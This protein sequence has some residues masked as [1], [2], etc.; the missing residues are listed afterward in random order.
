M[1]KKSLI[2][3]CGLMVMAG[4]SFAQNSKVRE[5]NRLY[6]TALDNIIKVS[7]MNANDP[8]ALNAKDIVE[9]MNGAKAAIDEAVLNEKTSLDADA[10]A[11]KGLIYIDLSRIPQNEDK[12]YYVEGLQALQKA[13]SLNP[14]IA[15]KDGVENALFNTAIFSFNGGIGASN[16][17]QYDELIQN[18]NVAKDALT[19]DKNGLFKDKPVKDTLLAQ[20]DYYIGFG[21]YSKKDYAATIKT[22]EAAVKNPINQESVDIY[23]V[24]ADSYGQTKQF[25]K[26]LD[27]INKAKA[28]FPRNKD[29]EIDELNYYIGQD[30]MEELMTKLEKAVTENPNNAEYRSN[31]GI[32]NRNMAAE[33]DGKLPPDALGWIVK[34]E[35]NLKKATE[36]AP[37]NAAYIYNLSTVY[38]IKADFYGNMMNALGSSKADNAKYEEYQ[39]LRMSSMREA[40]VPLAKVEEILSGKL[41]SKTIST[42]E[43]DYL[44]EALKDLRRLNAA[45]NQPEK[46]KEYKVKIDDLESK[47]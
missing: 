14:K 27:I 17:S 39:N 43:K 7:A 26:Q 42:T 32:L 41:K 34:A 24:L 15:K 29:L 36:L 20:A 37:D 13:Y 18:M 30:K 2:V 46:A 12:K 31:L 5:A 19:F 45:T 4:T 11:A 22:M 21:E 25:D 6:S 38:V 8:N 10:W 33:K 9:P 1:N 28:K 35:S 3:A 44:M 47:M 23:R 16:R 40:L